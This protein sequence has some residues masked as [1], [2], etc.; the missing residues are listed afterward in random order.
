M[1]RFGPSSLARRTGL[2]THGFWNEDSPGDGLQKSGLN[3]KTMVAIETLTNESTCPTWTIDPRDERIDVRLIRRAR[4]GTFPRELLVSGP[5]GT[6]KTLPI[7]RFIHMLCCEE[8]LRC[9]VMRATRKSLTESALVTYEEEVLAQDDMDFVRIGCGR[10]HR[11]AYAYPNGSTIVCA[12]LDDNEDRILSTAW[13]VVFGNEATGIKQEVWETL[14]SRMSR[15]GRSRRFGWM[16]ADTNPASPDHWFLKRVTA[17]TTEHWETTHRANPRMYDGEAW[18]EEGL[19]Y[20]DQL[21]GL[22]GVRRK[23]LLQGLWVAG[24][25]VW[26]DTFD[27]DI[28]VTPVAEYD[29]NLPV[30]VS[31]DCGVQTGAIIYQFVASGTR[32]HVIGDYLRESPN[33]ESTPAQIN[34]ERIFEVLH[35]VAPGHH[36]RVVSCDSAGDSRQPVGPT[37]ISEYERFGLTGSDRQIQRWPKFSGCITDGL[38]LIEAFIGGGEGECAVPASLFINPRC[39]AL[40]AAF[41]SYRRARSHGQWMD[42]PEDPQHPHEEM[43]DA[44]RGGLKIVSPEGRKPSLK[45]PR[46][47]MSRILP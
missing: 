1:L 14:A 9:L 26:F 8:Q 21:G 25:G 13:D 20:I 7:M 35:R 28:H 24:E 5:A 19:R 4:A 34:V 40:I 45:L 33:G 47:G 2:A 18:T 23:R 17:G 22:T 41:G 16:L 44:L 27:P 32:I 46:M 36:Y 31:I 38:N 43:I 30:Y 3:L 29:R 10:A 15:P 12:G 11:H 37:I 39:K 6:G 42:Y